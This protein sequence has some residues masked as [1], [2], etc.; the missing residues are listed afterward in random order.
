MS[1]SGPPSD[2]ELENDSLKGD[3]NE[4]D[5]TQDLAECNGTAGQ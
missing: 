1:V 2:A 5:I 3:N 4:A